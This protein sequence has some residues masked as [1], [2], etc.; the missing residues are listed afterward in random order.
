MCRPFIKKKKGEQPA[1]HP[2]EKRKDKESQVHRTYLQSFF[3]FN[4]DINN[5]IKNILIK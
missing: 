2:F 5:I 1:N 3:F 4:D